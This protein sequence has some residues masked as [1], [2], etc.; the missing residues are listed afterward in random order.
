MVPLIVGGE[1]HRPRRAAPVGVPPTG[2]NYIYTIFKQLIFKQLYGVF[3]FCCAREQ[4]E[5]EMHPNPEQFN[6][7]LSSV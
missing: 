7:I 6:F 2:D 1:G 5:F 3:C 4:D